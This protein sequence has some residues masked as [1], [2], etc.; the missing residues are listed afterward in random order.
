MDKKKQDPKEKNKKS[1]VE[2]PEEI[3]TSEEVVVK[4][5]NIDYK[6]TY[7]RALADYENLKREMAVKQ[8][9]WVKFGNAKIL[10]DLL[11]VLTHF[12][13]ALKFIPEV[14]QKENWV[15]GVMHIQKL[16]E[17]FMA[18][19][20]V[21][22]IETVGEE[23]DANLHESVGDREDDA[24]SGVIVEEVSA[25]YTLNGQVLQAARVIV[26]K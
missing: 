7:L 26:S 17:Q 14:Q 3:S 21:A 15:V 4:E 24:E 6:E 19:N 23:L 5:E 10:R 1:K 8:Q 9:E 2:N 18:D 20:G 22:K 16:F 13:Q 25:G 12:E 11:P